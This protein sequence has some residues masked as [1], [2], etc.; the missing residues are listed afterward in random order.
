MGNPIKYS[1]SVTSGSYQKGNNAIGVNPISYGPTSTTGWYNSPTPS[2]GNFI[3]IEVVDG[4][5]PPRFYAPSTL[6]DWVNLAKQEGATGNVTGSIANIRNWFTTQS[7]C[8]VTNIDFPSSLPNITSNGLLINLNTKIPTSYPGSGTTWTDVSGFN[9]N[10]TLY[11][12]PTFTNNS[13]VFDGVDDYM[14]AN[15][16]TTA[17]DGD[18]SFTVDMV[19]KRT[20]GTNI[21]PFSGFWGIGGA[22]QGNSVQGWTPTANLIHLDVYDS[23]RLTTDQYYP[24][25]RYIHLAWTKNGPE[26]ETTNVK[27]Y[28]NGVEYGLTKTRS[29]TRTNQFNTSTNG[30]GVCLGRINADAS[31]FQTPVTVNAF[32]V[33]N[34]ALSQT[35]ILQNYYQGNIITDS[36]VYAIDASNLVSYE[37]GSTTSYSLTGSNTGYL[38]YGTEFTSNNGGTFKFGNNRSTTIQ[39]ISASDYN[40][41]PINLPGYGSY[42]ISTWVKRT[43][44]GTWKSGNTNYDGI[45]NYY[46]DHSLAFTGENTGVNGIY[47]TGL[48][49]YTINM[50]QW[51]NIVVTHK[52][53]NVQSTNNHKTYLNGVLISTATI[54]NPTLDGGLPKRFYI[55]NWD[56]SWS[57]VG[58]IANLQ[59]YSK[60]LS[61]TEINQNFNA[62]RGKFGI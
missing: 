28:I 8:V 46:W 21:G 47:G 56:T 52:D 39:A 7:N 48:N 12:S 35:E 40:S 13:L 31:S 36:L 10:G 3:V 62:Y 60:E 22:G 24:E 29:A 15:I 55:G 30:I 57:M 25:N 1:T 9:S 49:A 61:S 58:E 17:L 18:P 11:N 37:S 54:T 41:S 6:T 33:Y 38:W 32:R 45:W 34:N 43:A 16:A 53:Y 14:Q 2:G 50:N 5:T 26:Q 19:V 27:C 42:T 23:T 4:N 44:F 59:I 51:Y 20:L